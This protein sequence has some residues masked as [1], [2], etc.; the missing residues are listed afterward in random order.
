VGT[1]H[2][3]HGRN[4]L[5]FCKKM[6]KG[7]TD[8]FFKLTWKCRLSPSLDEPQSCFGSFIV[9]ID[10]LPISCRFVADLVSTL[11]HT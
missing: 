9:W 4:F 6:C 2:Q 7:L 5:H 8:G 10:R 11:G 3:S 1:K